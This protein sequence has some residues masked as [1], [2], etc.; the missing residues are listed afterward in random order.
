VADLTPADARADPGLA[1]KLEEVS[2]LA[3]DKLEDF[4]L[5]PCAPDT[6]A[7]AKTLSAAQIIL[8]TQ[9]PSIRTS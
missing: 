4:L 2:R 1:A 6:S 5:A 3:L 7:F 9:I 8:N